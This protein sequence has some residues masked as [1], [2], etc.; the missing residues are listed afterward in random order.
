M[1][2]SDDLKGISDA[3]VAALETLW[4]ETAGAPPERFLNQCIARSRAELATNRQ[5]RATVR[6]YLTAAA[7]LLIGWHVSLLAAWSATTHVPREDTSV[8]AHRDDRRT[9]WAE[10]TAELAA[11][12]R[13]E[14][15]APVVPP[16]TKTRH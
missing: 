15:S 7:V 12:S 3:D 2:F 8:I 11:E 9:L 13:A 10:L 14:N 6:F 1:S 4:R 16:A 5:Q